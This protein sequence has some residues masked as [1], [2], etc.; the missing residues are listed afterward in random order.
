L[1]IA[2]IVGAILGAYFSNFVTANTLLGVNK[3]NPGFNNA[4]AFFAEA[5]MTCSLCLTILFIIIDK[6]VLVTFAPFVVGMAI[7]ICHMIGTPIDG[8]RYAR[9]V[10]FIPTPCLEDTNKHHTIYPVLTQLVPLALLSL[11]EYGLTSSGSS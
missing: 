4:Q 9:N 10:T 2:E 3:V 7:F 1:F 8:T 5:L 11:P 6:N